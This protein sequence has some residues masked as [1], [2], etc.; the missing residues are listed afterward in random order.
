MVLRSRGGINMP[1]SMFW[2]TNSG[3][4]PNWISPWLSTPSRP[5][6]SVRRSDS[7]GFIQSH[8]RGSDHA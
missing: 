7:P 1:I 4:P 5:K 3:A 2:I 6:L 8:C